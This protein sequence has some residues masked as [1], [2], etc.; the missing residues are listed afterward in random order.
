MKKIFTFISLFLVFHSVSYGQNLLLNSDFENGAFAPYGLWFS[1]LPTVTSYNATISVSADNPHLG[2]NSLLIDVLKTDPTVTNYYDNIW[3]VQCTQD[4]FSTTQGQKVLLSFWA[5]ADAPHVIQFGITKNSDPYNDYSME[6]TT[7]TTEWKKYEMVFI[8]PVTG[9]DIRVM[10]KCGNSVGQYYFDDISLTSQGMSDLNWYANA[11]KRIEELRKGDFTLTVKDANGNPLKN[12]DVAITLKHHDFKWGSAL[13]F[14][15]TISDD[16]AWYRNTAATYF[17]DAVFENDFKWQNMESVNGNVNYTNVDRYLDW[18]KETQVQ[19]RG[20]TLIWGGKQSSPPNSFWMTPS[21]LWNVSKDS[22]YSL[23]ERRIRRDV[24]HYKGKIFEYDVVN[25]PIHEGA[26]ATWLGDSLYVKAFKWAKQADPNAAL[27]INDYDNIDGTTTSMYKSFISYLLSK[28]APVEGIG[29]QCHLQSLID[30]QSIKQ[31]I[32]YLGDLGLPIKITEFDMNVQSI[33]LTEAQQASEYAKMMRIAFSHPDVEGFLFWGFWDRK[34]WSPNAG[35]FRTDKSAKPA[36][37][38]VYKLIHETWL[39][40]VN[41]KTDENGQISFRGFYGSYDIR[42]VGCVPG[43]FTEAIFTKD[44]KT[45]TVE[46][47]STITNVLSTVNTK[48]I[49]LFPNPATS[50]TSLL[51]TSNDNIQTEYV[52]VNSLGQI[53]KT[54]KVSIASGPNNV[55]IDV[56]DLKPGVYSFQMNINGSLYVSKLIKS[57]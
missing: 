44:V 19:F 42:A 23:I 22:A 32:D 47:S 46:L 29:V 51:L 55:D 39:T 50:S 2:S 34:H 53:V 12:C 43:K 36:A 37:D 18:G 20:H 17:N 15:P 8:S 11:D 52:L 28:N 54:K 16:E 31:R 1:P 10:F 3:R 35:I 40:K 7:I 27:Y 48:Q 49:T 21:W 38:S 33:G 9:T 14:L 6:A 26:L 25:E 57:E 4:G 5:R 13:A 24:G 45:A 41:L 30:W 56:V